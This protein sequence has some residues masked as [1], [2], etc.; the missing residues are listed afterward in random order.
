[1]EEG[2]KIKYKQD[3]MIHVFENVTMKPLILYA[4]LNYKREKNMCCVI[5]DSMS[6]LCLHPGSSM[7]I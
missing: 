3:P 4:N 6:C 2:R 7:T 5:G 1:M